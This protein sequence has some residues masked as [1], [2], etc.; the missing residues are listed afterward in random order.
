MAVSLKRCRLRN[1]SNLAIIGR[2][3]VF[4]FRLGLFPTPIMFALQCGR[5]SEL[6][7]FLVPKSLAM[8]GRGYVL[9][10]S[11]LYFKEM[12]VTV[13]GDTFNIYFD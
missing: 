7:T 11:N 3:Y 10:L 5:G 13:Y 8:M 6:A 9:E 1:L 4:C 2:G 12:E